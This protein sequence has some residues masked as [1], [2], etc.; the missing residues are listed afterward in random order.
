M[1]FAIAR[2]LQPPAGNTVD[3]RAALQRG[4]ADPARAATSRASPTASSGPSAPARASRSRSTRPSTRTTATSSRSSTTRRSSTRSRTSTNIRNVSGPGPLRRA[5][6]P[7]H[8]PAAAAASTFDPNH[9]LIIGDNGDINLAPCVI[10]AIPQGERGPPADDRDAAGQQHRGAG[11][12]RDEG[13]GARSPSARRTARYTQRRSAQPPVRATGACRVSALFTQAGC[14]ACH[15]TTLF[16]NSIKDSRRRPP[17]AP[18][19]TER[20]R[21]RL[22]RRGQP[23]RP[24]RTSSSSCTNIGSF[25]LGVP[26]A[27]NPIGNNIGATELT[28]R[29]AS[30]GGPADDAAAR[31]ARARL[32][33]RR[34]GERLRHPVVLGIDA[35]AA[36]LPQRRVR[37]ARLRAQQRPGAAPPPRRSP[38]SRPTRSRS[39]GPGAVIAFRRSLD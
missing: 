21:T 10:N 38:G 16:S 2:R 27:G 33:R 15:G 28:T 20:P 14:A 36:L 5:A 19:V 22:R 30:R 39:A 13:V 8:A 32:Q 18:V 9:G 37:D 4:L 1:F 35:V 31:R 25:N 3:Q 7:V 11:A 34:Q 24:R 23:G 26:G 12:D 17:A 6:L 29:A